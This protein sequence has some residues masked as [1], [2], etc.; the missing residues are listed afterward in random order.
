MRGEQQHDVIYI[1]RQIDNYEEPEE[2]LNR[3][4]PISDGS[5]EPAW[6]KL[7]LLTPLFVIASMLC[8]Y[9]A[10]NKIVVAASGIILISLLS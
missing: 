9:M 3:I 4:K 10:N 8:V 2:E 5:T 7:R 1:P 6:K